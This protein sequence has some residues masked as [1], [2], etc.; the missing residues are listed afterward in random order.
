ML[1]RKFFVSGKSKSVK[2]KSVNRNAEI[3]R[4]L[5]DSFQVR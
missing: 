2:S 5:M 3:V 4:Y 1:I